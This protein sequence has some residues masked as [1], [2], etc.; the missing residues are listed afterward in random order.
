M[1]EK[2]LLGSI[3]AT[4]PNHNV[5]LE[6]LSNYANIPYPDKSPGNTFKVILRPFVT[7]A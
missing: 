5:A 6:G 1:R 2:G 7:P 4:N 3:L